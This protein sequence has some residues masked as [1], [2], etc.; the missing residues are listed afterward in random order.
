MM[1]WRRIGCHRCHGGL[2]KRASVPGQ[3][4]QSGGGAVLLRQRIL[5]GKAEMTRLLLEENRHDWRRLSRLALILPTVP[6]DGPAPVT[7]S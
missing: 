4:C 3:V 7:V 2:V 6:D 5:A 1:C